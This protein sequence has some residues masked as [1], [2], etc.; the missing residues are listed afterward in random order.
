MKKSLNQRRKEFLSGALKYYTKD[1]NRR[2]VTKNNCY[3]SPESM[4]N[5]NSDGCLIGRWLTPELKL[6]LDSNKYTKG[7]N[8]STQ[9]VFSRLPTVLQNLGQIFLARC[10]N[11]HDMPKFWTSTGLSEYGK[12][13][14][15]NIIEEFELS[16]LK[17]K[18]WLPDD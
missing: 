14:V 12:H 16:P 7:A 10:Q 17:F 4:C 15:K 2:C 3:Y 5:K 8:V 18:K 1:V 11:L 6:E 13:E 9:I